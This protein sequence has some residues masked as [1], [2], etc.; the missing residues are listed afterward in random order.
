MGLGNWLESAVNFGANAVG[1][2]FDYF[3]DFDFSDPNRTGFAE[4]LL[5]T[6]KGPD[7]EINWANL[8]A[9]GTSAAYSSGSLDKALDA[10]G[11]DFLKSDANTPSPTGY[12]GGIPEYVA[13]QE[14]VPQS[15]IATPKPGAMGQR[16]FSDVIYAQKPA[17][18]QIPT[19]E[20]AQ[21]MARAQ[22]GLPAL[23]GGTGTGTGT[24][25]ATTGGAQ[26]GTQTNPQ[27]GNNAG[28]NAGTG[29]TSTGGGF[30]TGPITDETFY[31]DPSER[32][33][34]RAAGG[35]LGLAK[36]GFYLGGPTDGM[37]DKVPARIDG[38][39]E[40]RLSDGEFVVPAD[41]V[42]HLGNGNSNAGAQQLYGMMDRV[43]KARTGRES[44]G[45]QINPSKY[46]PGMR[47]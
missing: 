38:R 12:Q 15:G 41:V 28:N 26:G 16:Y 40:A 10:L 27:T 34:L 24:G 37:A 31:G 30:G 1:S 5:G 47:A 11:L 32:P 45:K 13:V 6:L 2:A 21:A 18:S 25:G 35:L 39:Q 44:Q 8:I 17:G 29:N 46:M 22:V 7:G 23:T 42:S 33:E 43:R 4:D 14:R 3:T 19:L 36:G 20:Q 9:L